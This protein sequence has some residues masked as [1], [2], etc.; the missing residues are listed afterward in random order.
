MAEFPFENLR[1]CSK[2]FGSDYSYKLVSKKGTAFLQ[3]LTP[4]SMIIV[5]CMKAIGP[6]KV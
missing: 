1:K 4:Q 2:S 3:P 6:V 5:Y